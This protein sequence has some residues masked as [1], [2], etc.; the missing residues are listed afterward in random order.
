[1]GSELT[2]FFNLGM[3]NDHGEE[4]LSLFTPNS[5]E[6][7]LRVQEKLWVSNVRRFQLNRSELRLT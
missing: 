3:N 5:I 2:L 1:M 4:T 6:K 7:V